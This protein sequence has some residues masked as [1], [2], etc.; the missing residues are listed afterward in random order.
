MGALP[1]KLP[2]RWQ[3]FD[4]N[5]L[6]WRPAPVP[7]AVKVAVVTAL[8]QQIPCR[9][10]KKGYKD[11]LMNY[12]SSTS[13]S[14]SE[15]SKI[16]SAMELLRCLAFEIKGL[17]GLMS[18]CRQA[19]PG[20]EIFAEKSK[21]L[22]AKSTT[23]HPCLNEVEQSLAVAMPDPTPSLSHEEAVVSVASPTVP[24]TVAGVPE[25]NA[26]D[27]AKLLEHELALVKETPSTEE[28]EKSKKKKKATKDSI[29]KNQKLDRPRKNPRR[30]RS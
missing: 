20:L 19:L 1:E 17:P 21:T 25:G 28:P 26:V 29:K 18:P 16:L 15:S 13:T 23:L 14:L 22:A 2:T 27:K 30:S 6:S 12:S 10:S 5:I 7:H 3:E 24:T 9:A 4:P 8:T 11:N